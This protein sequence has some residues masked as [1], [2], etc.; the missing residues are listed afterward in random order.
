MRFEVYIVLFGSAD[1][2]TRRMT[3]VG[4]HHLRRD[5]LDETIAASWRIPTG[6]PNCP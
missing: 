6:S 1:S 4:Q 2:N 3:V 5:R